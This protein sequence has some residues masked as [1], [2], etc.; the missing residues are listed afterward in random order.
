MAAKPISSEA[1]AAAARQLGYALEQSS[2]LDEAFSRLHEVSGEPQRRALQELNQLLS[3]PEK[4]DGGSKVSA[5]YPTLRWI[6]SQAPDRGRAA[7]P[8]FREF[9]RQQSFSAAS[10]AVVW[11][12]FSGFIVYLGAVLGVLV[13]V[14]SMYSIFTLPN[15]R[16]LYKGF[17]SDLPEVTEYVFGGRS[18]L[19]GSLLLLA[20]LALAILGWFVYRLRRQLRRY[21][22]MP[23]GFRRIPLLGPVTR[24]YDEYLWLAWA[25]LLR[26]AGVPAGQALRISGERLGSGRT[27][28]TPTGARDPALASQLDVAEKLGR[29]D[30]E[31]QFQQD[32]SVDGFLVSLARCRRR[33]RLV[34]TVLTYFL[35]GMFVSAMYLPLFSL[36]SSL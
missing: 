8:V 18:L 20:V 22:P 14:A 21:M 7:W 12:E 29:L 2:G 17:N 23:A 31:L 24:A 6:L 1:L 34:L 25:G 4:S 16:S 11:S 3:G 32:A 33:T 13:L 19:F 15:I 10:I 36:G 28:S 35:V 30:D 5:P 9:R 26:A 27:S